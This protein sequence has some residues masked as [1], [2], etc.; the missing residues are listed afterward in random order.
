MSQPSTTPIQ[1]IGYIVAITLCCLSGC[2]RIP[3]ANDTA[4]NL[5]EGNRY[6]KGFALIPHNGFIE[7]V[8]YNPWQTTGKPK[9]TEARYY[10]IKDTS[11]TT[12]PDGI[13]L[14]V[15]LHRLAITSCTHAGF[16]QALDVSTSICGV[17]HP[18]LI[19]N[20]LP[21]SGYTDIGDAMQ[22][23]AERILLSAPEAI[24]ATAYQQGGHQWDQLRNAD[25]KI[26][27]NNEWTEQHPLARAEWIRFVAAFYDLLPQADSLFLATENAYNRLCALAQEAEKQGLPRRSLL[28]GS[29][30]RGT[31]YVPSGNTY[32]GQLFHDA[33]ADYYYQNDSTGGSLPLSL[34]QIL[35]HF[36]DADVWIG[37][38]ALSREQLAREDEKH[39][40]FNAWQKGEVYNFCKRS[41]ARGANDFWETGVVRPDLLLSDIIRTLYPERLD[42]NHVFFF[43]RRLE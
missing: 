11:V 15:P 36:K 8:V 30:F 7:A 40:W 18:E 23:N 37:C 39:T 28:T 21:D 32:M 14:T 31:W 12:P 26:I 4:G 10:L 27:C 41:N 3:S 35:M 20:P 2:G 5:P 34:E 22:L 29:N 25:I 16:L 33:G 13:R 19:Y 24:M 17:C 9:E 42:S 6:A 1:R 43:T 38:N